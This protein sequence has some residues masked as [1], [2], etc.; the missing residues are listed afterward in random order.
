MSFFP[1]GCFIEIGSTNQVDSRDPIFPS[2]KLSECVHD[3]QA[4]ALAWMG[5]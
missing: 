2:S 3:T 4:E 5:L 1:V